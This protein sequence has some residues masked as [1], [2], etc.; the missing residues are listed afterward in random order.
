MLLLPC[1][2]F[3]LTQEELLQHQQASR[4]GHVKQPQ[5]SH[6]SAAPAAAA[7]AVTGPPVVVVDGS[8]SGMQLC[9]TR[10]L[11]L[12]GRTPT[13]G[14]SEEGLEG[15]DGTLVPQQPAD[16][17]AVNGLAPGVKFVTVRWLTDSLA[18]GRM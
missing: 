5:H 16:K 18:A 11:Q 6:A 14:Q 3:G 17:F 1:R 10:Q 13:E 12:E 2:R 9:V 8:P 7:A 4:E 15:Y